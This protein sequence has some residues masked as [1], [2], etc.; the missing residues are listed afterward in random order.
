MRSDNQAETKEMRRPTGRP[1]N[2]F[3]DLP[4]D[5]TRRVAR[6]GITVNVLCPGY[7]ESE[8]LAHF[9]PEKRHAAVASIPMRRFGRPSEVAAVVRFLASPDAGYVTG[10]EIKVDGGIL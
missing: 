7:I 9:P 10:A 6:L 1:L 5:A 2:P 4:T 3:R 8:A